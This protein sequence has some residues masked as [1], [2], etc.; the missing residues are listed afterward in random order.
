MKSEFRTKTLEEQVYSA[1]TCLGGIV[2]T[3]LTV[4][5]IIEAYP[6]VRRDTSVCY[7]AKPV[8]FDAGISDTPEPVGSNYQGRVYVK[9]KPKKRPKKE[10]RIFY[11]FSGGESCTVPEPATAATFIL[12][13]AFLLSRKRK[14]R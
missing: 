9:E 4:I 5:V 12:G 3:L 7:V 11:D 10:T 1:A 2:L 14:N 8:A 6:L 13:S